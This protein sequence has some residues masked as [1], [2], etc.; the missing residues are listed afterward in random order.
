MST[1]EKDF[2][3]GGT[4]AQKLPNFEPRAQQLEMA[5][6]VAH[7]LDNG[8]HLF[9]EAGTG[10]GKT[11]AYLLPALRSRRRVIVST[12]TKTLQHQLMDK[13]IPLLR[14][15]AGNVDAV[16]LKGRQNYLCPAAFERFRAQ[17]SFR[18]LEEE[19]HWQQ[20]EA[21]AQQ[22]ETGD[23]GE[24]D[25]LPEDASIWPRLTATADQCAGKDC[26]HYDRCFLVQQRERANEADIIVVNHHLF[27][28]DCAVRERMDMRLLPEA[29]ALV[30]DE[31]HHLEETAAAFFTI[32]VSNRSLES[33][34]SDIDEQLIGTAQTTLDVASQRGS[35]HALESALSF[36]Q[37][38]SDDFWERVRLSLDQANDPAVTGRA[39]RAP[40][41]DSAS[42]GET[43]AT[44]QDVLRVESEKIFELQRILQDSLTALQN[45]IKEGGFGEAGTRLKDRVQTYSNDLMSVLRARESDDE[46]KADF[47][48]L[49][50]ARRG[51]VAIEAVPLDVRPIFWR[52][53]FGRRGATIVT[54]AT[55]ATDGNFR[56]LRARVGAPEDAVELS[57][58]SP[59]DYLR[60]SV[61]YVP[62]T[63]P[64]PNAPDFVER[65]APEIEALVNITKGRA[66]VLFTSYRNMRQAHALLSRRWR[67]KTFIQGEMSK[68]RLL[69]EFRKHKN[70]VLFAT[71]SFWEGVDVPGDALSLVII[72]KLPFANPSDPLTS[73]RSRHVEQHGGNSFR[74]YS[75]P[76]AIIQ[77]KQGFGR[78][79]RTRD[80][81][82]IVA[83]LDHRLLN[84]PYGRRFV[85]SLPRARRTQDIDLVKR[86]WAHVTAQK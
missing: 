30:F 10:T 60:Q 43:R 8:E 16:L 81:L 73:A 72:D 84:K 24:L 25:R 38:S 83:I 76:Q 64:E 32:H 4:L 47:I 19:R 35:T 54:S 34:T 21:W 75:V 85:E 15:L 55:L 42:D 11:L 17:P 71:A 5:E 13:D 61:L 37:T 1:V 78:L 26:A 68:G 49:A 86:W 41:L 52:H 77:L 9:V 33:I 2:G 70:S 23:R 65:I 57:L 53:V 59:F 58:P 40:L 48:Y 62:P 22:T 51:L 27:F 82:G 3:E 45:A 20:I 66:F 69:E 7:A 31:G 39:A 56:F 63:L 46:K 50:I 12:A 67:Y 6:A 29:E 28:A 14:Q 18:T 74:D 80:D 44:L 79:I 36:V